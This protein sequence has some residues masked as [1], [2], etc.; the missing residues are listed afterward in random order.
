MTK[1]S[2]DSPRKKHTNA[3]L[4]KS[5]TFAPNTKQASMPK[6]ADT[7]SPSSEKLLAAPLEKSLDKIPEKTA[8]SLDK[9][10]QAAVR[11]GKLLRNLMD[12]VRARQARRA[13][14]VWRAGVEFL[15]GICYATIAVLQHPI[16]SEGVLEWTSMDVGLLGIRARIEAFDRRIAREAIEEAREREERE[17]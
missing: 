17:R 12:E 4:S 5:I 10:T 8:P 15:R 7:A 14:V 1:T 9:L 13:E 6:K 2:Y 16:V 3:P 11:L